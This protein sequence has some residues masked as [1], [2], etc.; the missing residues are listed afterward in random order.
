VLERAQAENLKKLQFAAFLQGV[1][2]VRDF[3]REIH[4]GTRCADRSQQISEIVAL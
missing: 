4:P 3:I 1:K 2:F